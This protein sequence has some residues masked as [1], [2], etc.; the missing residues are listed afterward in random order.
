MIAENTEKTRT[1]CDKRRILIV[2]DERAIRRLFEMVLLSEL[3]EH[4]IDS[5]EDGSK[6]LESFQQHHHALLLMDLKMPV[7]DGAETFIEI[8]KICRKLNWE[9][10]SV[11]FCSGYAPPDAVKRVISDSRDLHALVAK[12]VRNETLV[13]IVRRRLI[14]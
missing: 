1:P 12:P 8:E 2:D 11:I 13:E 10:P 4:M 6:A 14:R 5:A 9:M 7:M 3:P